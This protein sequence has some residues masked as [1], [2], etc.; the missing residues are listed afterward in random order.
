[1]CKTMV[2]SCLLLITVSADAQDVPKFELFG[3][4]AFANTAGTLGDQGRPNLNG[5]NASFT[6]NLNRW[7]GLVADF[8]GSD[9][10]TGATLLAPTFTACPTPPCVTLTPFSRAI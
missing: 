2:L 9:G 5:W 8:G 3:G 6:A 10:S 4:Y 1:M 7:T